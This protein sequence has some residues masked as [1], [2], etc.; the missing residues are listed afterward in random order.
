MLESRFGMGVV[1]TIAALVLAACGGG[2]ETFGTGSV[3]WVERADANTLRIFLTSCDASPEIET[4][5]VDAESMEITVGIRNTR[6]PTDCD[7]IDS[8]DQ[9]FAEEGVWTVIN[10]PSGERHEIE[11]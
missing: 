7:A 3:Q 10:G 8:V 9:Q 6:Q 2:P 5:E 4:W 1:A 11:P